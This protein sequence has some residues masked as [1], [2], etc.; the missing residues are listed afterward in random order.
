MQKAESNAEK[1]KAEMLKSRPGAPLRP[2]SLS[3]FQ[4][5]CL[6]PSVFCLLHSAFCVLC[7]AAPA[8]L[9][10]PVRIWLAAQTNLSTWSADFV[11]TRTLQS[12]TQPLTSKGHGWFAA[13]E[14][15][16]W[17]L[18]HPPETIAVCAQ[19]HLLLFYPRLKRVERIPLTGNQTGPWRDALAM[20]EAGFPRSE[21]ELHERYDVLSQTVTN[22]TGRLVLQPRSA[23]ARR[24]MPRIEIDFDTEDHSLS[25]TELEFSDGSTLRNDFSNIVLNPELDQKLFTPP[26]PP[27]YTVVAPL[28]KR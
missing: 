14:R 22:H 12:L 2:F 20:L 5:C 1:L 18:G 4:R 27:D 24:I 25:G 19:N 15:F 13:P 26:I 8:P 21:A 6:L 16:R 17:E 11:Q 7:F 3:A 10:P 23:A 9:S 28:S